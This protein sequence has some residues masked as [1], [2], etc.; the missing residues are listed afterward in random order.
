MK[1]ARP[2]QMSGKIRIRVT[3][4]DGRAGTLTLSC[5]TT[6]VELKEMI[7]KELNVPPSQ[8]LLRFGIPPKLFQPSDPE[9]AVNLKN[10][11]KVTVEVVPSAEE[12]E[13]SN[14]LSDSSTAEPSGQ[15]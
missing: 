9:A 8:Q 10:G 11:D 5:H 2:A 13:L 6:F 15:C 3:T 1:K 7:E 4:S 14:L 12:P